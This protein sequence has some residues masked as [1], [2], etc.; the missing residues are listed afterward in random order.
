MYMY[1]VVLE[2]YL[3]NSVWCIFDSV[4]SHDNDDDDDEGC[5][6]IPSERKHRAMDSL[7][8][9]CTTHVYCMYI[10]IKI[11]CLVKK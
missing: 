9:V 2:L 3:S 7:C 8:K 4:E 5:I 10:Y 1:S 6:D 11:G